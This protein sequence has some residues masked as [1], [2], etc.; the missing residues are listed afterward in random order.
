MIRQKVA[1]SIEQAI[2]ELQKEGFLPKLPVL[3]LEIKE[4][5]KEIYGDYAS[6][7]ALKIAKITKK[8][9][10][11]V[12]EK[13]SHNIKRKNKDFF[14]QIEVI[15]PGFINFF[16]SQKQLRKELGEALAGGE[17]FGKLTAGKKIKA[18]VEF[19]SA[20]PTGPLHIGNGRG[21]FFG[22]CLAN[23]LAFAGF[24]A[25]R[26]YY[27][28]DTKNSTQILELGKTALDQGQSYL[29]PY[30]ES[31]ILKLKPHLKKIKS[32]SEAGF[33]V[34]QNILGDIKK[35]VSEKLK[36]KIDFWIQEHN[37][38]RQD[39]VKKIYDTLKKKNLIY[40]KDK[41]TWLKLDAFDLEDGVLLRENGQPTYFLSDIAYHKDKIDRGFKKIIDIWGADH[42]GHVPRMKAVMKILGFKGE[43]DILISQMVQLE[44]EKI[45]K[46][47]GKIILL[48]DLVDAVGLDAVKFFYLMKSLN[49]QMSFNLALAKE[50]SQ[51][52]PVFYVQYAHARICSI[53]KKGKTDSL[54]FNTKYLEFLEH[55][56]EIKLM[57]KIIQLPEIIEDTAK[58]Y[59][60]QRLPQYALELAE[61]FH[62]FYRDCYVLSKDKNLAQARLLL[63]FC[64]KNTL[65]TTLNLM[66]IQ[67]PEKM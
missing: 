51:K 11:E 45:S 4:S 14:N 16:I 27:V 64:A 56:S 5:Q 37:L 50:K 57:R 9:P 43:F 39:K 48:E 55:P 19:I 61:S 34:A 8:Q 59:Q 13:I 10:L 12:A 58:D 24:K 47:A 46:R 3:N 52:N 2:K 33:F 30:L 25:Y 54:K 53:L 20:N 22:D 62:S 28:N 60:L 63:A 7:V 67:A 6:S 31:L 41:A 26:E 15:K 36:I 38:F 29:S 17:N 35:F 42:Q 44:G 1:K 21:A 66:G 40:E 49:T 32:E 18:N 65:K 23:I